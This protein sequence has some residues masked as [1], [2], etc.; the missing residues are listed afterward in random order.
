MERGFFAHD[1]EITA[2]SQR[3]LLDRV[4]EIEMLAVEEGPQDEPLCGSNL[5]SFKER[6][7]NSGKNITKGAS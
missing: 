1:V 3:A 4:I 7:N 6:V 5:G 2:G